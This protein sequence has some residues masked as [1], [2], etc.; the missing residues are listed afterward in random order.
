VGTLHLL[1]S[2]VLIDEQVKPDE[3]EP[4]RDGL[5]RRMGMLRGVRIDRRLMAL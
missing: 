4:Y 1:A 5:G 3:G 2:P